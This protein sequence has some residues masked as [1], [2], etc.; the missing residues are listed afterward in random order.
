MQLM[1][2]MTEE[3]MIIAMNFLFAFLNTWGTSQKHLSRLQNKMI[4]KSCIL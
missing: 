1:S 2:A 3:N 4:T